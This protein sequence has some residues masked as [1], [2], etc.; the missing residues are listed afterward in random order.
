MV[1]DGDFDPHPEACAYLKWLQ[2]GAGRSPGTARTYGSRVAA[3]L[4]WAETS[5]IDWRRPSL[6]Q[7]ADLVRWLHRGGRNGTDIT[8]RSPGY[9]NL[10]LTA[11]GGF[12]RFCA[13]H[14]K[15][16]TEVADR[17]SEPRFLRDLPQ[18]F[19]PGESGNR[20]VRRSMLRMKA[21]IK[22]PKFLDTGQQEAV[23]KGTRNIRDRFLVELLFGTG[24]RVGEACGLH[25]QDMHFLPSSVPLGCRFTGPHVHVVRRDR[26]SNGALA[27]S[28]I[29]RTIPVS[30]QL[31]RLYADYQQERWAVLAETEESAF[32]FVNL[33]RAPLGLPLRP[34]T[35]E[36]L[37][38]RL[39][40]EAG[41]KVTP[42]TCRHTFATRLVRAGVDRD[43]VQALLGHVSPTS[44]AIYTHAD[45]SDLRAAV[46]AVGHSRREAGAR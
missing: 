29:P 3:Y 39:S 46:D 43:V 33:Y 13:L 17:L 21:P 9:V 19:D 5:S 32:V 40:R 6:D 31:A 16:P 37:F 14:G 42:H 36:E 25:R 2:H 10:G 28:L 30:P 34:D 7:L 24:L 23:V 27:K 4:T 38:E 41:V 15:V 20:V 35:V 22:P 45:W 12:L 1:L 44:T 26:N 18:G 8:P 11:I